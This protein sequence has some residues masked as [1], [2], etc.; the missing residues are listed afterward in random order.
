MIRMYPKE[1]PAGRRKKPKRQAER[2]VYEALA[3]IHRQGFCYYEWRKGYERIELD[4]AVWIAGLGRFALQVKGGRYLLIDGEWYLKTREGLRLIRTCPLDETRLAALDLHDDIKELAETRYNPF[5]IPV[6]VFPDM[7]PDQA[8]KQLARR[9]GVYIVWGSEDLSADLAEIVLS[10]RVSDRLPM[11][12]I[13]GE[14]AAITDGLIRLVEAQGEETVGKT[15]RPI[16]LTLRAA[17]QNIV[18]IRAR[19]TRLRHETAIRPGAPRR[20]GD[21]HG[22]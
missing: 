12:R 16:T 7:E 15:G 22:P 21:G 18:H 13:A 8:I 1:F 6:L 5:V 9:K 10:R 19:E 11:E 20:E 14:V 17:G 3:G 4:F 2:R